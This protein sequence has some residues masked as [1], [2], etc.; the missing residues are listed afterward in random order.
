MNAVVFANETGLE[1][2]ILSDVLQGFGYDIAVIWRERYRGVPRQEGIDLVVSLGS[3]WSLTSPAVVKQVAHELETLSDAHQR[4]VPVI[5]ICFGA[6]LLSN[7]LGGKVSRAIKPEIGWHDVEATNSLQAIAGKW[8]QW[9]YDVFTV[10]IEAELLAI[11][12]SGPQ[13]F[14]IGRSF[15]TQF[16]PEV[17]RRLLE[18]WISNGGA[19][20]LRAI[21][22]D[23]AVLLHE[24][25]AHYESSNHRFKLLLK[26]FFEFV[27][28]S[29]TDKK[30]TIRL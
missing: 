17:S 16:H 27:A 26:W 21:E 4:G 11:N 9:H 8:M 6:Q 12:L 18:Q 30:R 7:A 23:P 15:G 2:D 10:P 13:A 14:R 3:D 1:A 29:H 20:E 5:G 19:K 22:I 24:S 28:Y 25:E